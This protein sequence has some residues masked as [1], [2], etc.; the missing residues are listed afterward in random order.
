MALSKTISV[1]ARSLE[2]QL[3][4]IQSNH[5]DMLEV[6]KNMP[7]YLELNDMAVWEADY[8]E[9]IGSMEDENSEAY[10]AIDLLYELAGTNLFVAFDK[11]ETERV[12]K[13]VASELMKMHL[14]IPR[15]LDVSEW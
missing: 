12:Y 15:N 7:T 6:M 4:D 13:Y 5:Q 10:K 11:R 3:G 1:L 9:A 8:R 2:K 14:E